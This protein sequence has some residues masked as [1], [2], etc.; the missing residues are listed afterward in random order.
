MAIKPGDIYNQ[1]VQ[2]IKMKNGK[3]TII[4]VNDVCY[5]MDVAATEKENKAK[6]LPIPEKRKRLRQMKRIN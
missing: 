1:K 3:P 2:I 5:R 6:K 4:K